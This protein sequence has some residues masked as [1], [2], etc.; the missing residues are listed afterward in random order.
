MELG[1]RKK[2]KKK[3]KGFVNGFHQQ[4]VFVFDY[5]DHFRSNFFE[6]HLK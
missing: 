1:D 5:F 2:K 4:I 6:I 3:R